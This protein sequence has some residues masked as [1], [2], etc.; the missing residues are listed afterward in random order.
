MKVHEL[1]AL[2]LQQP[3]ELPVYLQT[4][5]SVRL[6]TPPVKVDVTPWNQS[7]VTAVVLGDGPEQ[8]KRFRIAQAEALDELTAAARS[9]K[10]ELMSDAHTV[11]VVSVAAAL[12]AHAPAIKEL[13][14]YIQKQLK[15]GTKPVPI[16]G[17]LPRN[18]NGE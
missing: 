14:D 8:D 7:T 10:I 5:Y 1:V 13:N 2:L 6:V 18:E 12:Q 4:Y 9:A 16:G 17:S 15:K 11:S 3:Q